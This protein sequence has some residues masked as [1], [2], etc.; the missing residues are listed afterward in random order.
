MSNTEWA[1][2]SPAEGQ[3]RD[4]LLETLKGGHRR[5]HGKQPG[6]EPLFRVIRVFRGYPLGSE[7]G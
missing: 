3:T 7:P 5:I 4:S 1:E 2:L 6:K